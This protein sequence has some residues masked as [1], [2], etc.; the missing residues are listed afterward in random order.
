[1]VKFEKRGAPGRTRTLDLPLRR[2]LLYPAELLVH[3]NVATSGQSPWWLPVGAGEGNRTLDIQLGRLSLYQLS[4]SRRTVVG[5]AGFEPTTPC[6][7]SRCA[8]RLR[9]APVQRSKYTE[10]GW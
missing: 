9:Y 8:T 5:A 10:S 3:R 2:R 4:Y 7:Q 1:M 6:S